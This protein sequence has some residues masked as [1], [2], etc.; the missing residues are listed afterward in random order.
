MRHQRIPVFL[1]LALALSAAPAFAADWV[2]I[3]SM[4]PASPA[5]LPG[6]PTGSPMGAGNS[7]EV[8]FT[9][10]LESQATG[11]IGFYTAG[12]PGNP[13]HTGLENPFMVTKKGQGEGKT[14]F[15]V[16]CPEGFAGCT[17]KTVRYDLFHD[18]P[19]PAGLTRLFEGH[20]PV[21]YT[22]KC[23]T[24]NDKKP[25]VAF[26]RPGIYIWGS[27]PAKKHWVD[28]NGSVKLTAAESINPHPTPSNGR[29]A[30]NVEYY[31][32][33]TNGVATPPFKNRLYSDGDERAING[34]FALTASELKS[35][36]TQPYLDSGAHGF[37]VVL[38]ADGNVNETSEADNSGSIR[39]HLE[40]RCDS[41][42]GTSPAAAATKH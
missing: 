29:C 12:E 10:N 31:E 6:V 42:P 40:G 37:K 18:A 41:K 9:Y 39:Y 22:F 11:R 14:R 35:I 26:A 4:N 34:P 21:D 36:V 38:D 2:R 3:V 20:Q 33:E 16:Q 15:S 25:N 28:W 30:F 1:V 8:V 17:I 19:P 23:R 13:P 5:T 32:K 7:I 24:P 27:D